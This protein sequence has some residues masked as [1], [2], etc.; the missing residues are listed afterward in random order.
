[1]K[2]LNTAA[3]KSTWHTCCQINCKIYF[4]HSYQPRFDIIKVLFIHQL[5]H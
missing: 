3:W 4:S 2:E 5:M 1:L